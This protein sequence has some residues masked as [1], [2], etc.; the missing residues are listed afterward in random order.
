[1][2]AEDVIVGLNRNPNNFSFGIFDIMEWKREYCFVWCDPTRESIHNNNHQNKENGILLERPFVKSIT[3]MHYEY[4][5]RQDKLIYNT[6]KS[7]KLLTNDGK[8]VFNLLHLFQD[9]EEL[10]VDFP[11]VMTRL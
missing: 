4:D 6:E 1:M 3:P 5:N 8:K 7:F 11:E 9:V 2:L 10:E